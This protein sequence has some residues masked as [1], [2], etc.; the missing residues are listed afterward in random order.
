VA[1]RLGFAKKNQIIHSGHLYRS[2][3]IL[4]PYLSWLVLDQLIDTIYSPQRRV[5]GHSIEKMPQ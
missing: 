2:K 3:E 4:T 1:R 5:G